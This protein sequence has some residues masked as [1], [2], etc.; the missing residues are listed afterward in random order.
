MDLFIFFSIFCVCQNHS[1]NNEIVI[2]AHERNN[3]NN[4]ISACKNKI[5]LQKH[6]Y[7]LQ[8]MIVPDYLFSMGAAVQIRIFCHFLLIFNCF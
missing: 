4:N 5:D 6:F 3:K 7:M 8:Y 1:Y 2:S